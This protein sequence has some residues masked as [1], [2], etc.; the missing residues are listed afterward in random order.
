LSDSLNGFRSYVGVKLEMHFPPNFQRRLAA[1]LYVGY[2]N[3]FEEQEWYGPPLSLCQVRSGWDFT[4]PPPAGKFGVCPSRF[5][6]GK[7]CAD[8]FAIKAFE[9]GHAF[10]MPLDRGMSLYCVFRVII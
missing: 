5:L 3:V 2:E 1:K 6:N 10:E 4:P 8:D 9:Y 7:V